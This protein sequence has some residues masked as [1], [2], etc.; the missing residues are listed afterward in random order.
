MQASPVKPLLPV[1]VGFGLLLLAWFLYFSREVPRVAFSPDDMM[2]IDNFYWSRGPW[3]LL[4][5]QFLFWRGY[6]RPMGGLFYLPI[7]SVW[8]LNPVPYHVALSLVLLAN[9]CLVYRLARLLGCGELSAGVSA[10]VVCYHAGLANLY[11]NTAFVYDALCGFF[12]F[13]ALVY[14]IALR[15]TGR[16]LG[17][18]Q[19]LTFCALL[20]CALNSKEMALSLAGVLLAYEWLYHPPAGRRGAQLV[21]WLRGPGRVALLAACLTLLDLCGKVWGY[22]ALT[23]MAGY[24][25]VFS[26]QRFLAYQ[27]TFL[28]DAAF[29]RCGGPGIL[30]FWT[31]V[32]YLAWRPRA[33]PVLRFCWAFR[34]SHSNFSTPMSSACLINE[35]VM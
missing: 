2:N 7:F 30:A 4:Y 9:V 3:S 16:L 29:L 6:Y 18:R 21:E 23:G 32:S 31:V 13:A 10:L 5:S 27:K 25:P 34:F 1:K 22:D 15:N 19:T 35:L 17:G 28:G 33:R 12:S 11:Y 8:G 24:Q 26:W 14:Y 20:V